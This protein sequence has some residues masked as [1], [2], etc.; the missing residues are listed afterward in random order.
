[1]PSPSP[2]PTPPPAGPNAAFPLLLPGCLGPPLPPQLTLLQLIDAW[3]GS[4]DPAVSKRAK[5]FSHEDA[6]LVVAQLLYD[7]YVQLAFGHTAYVS[8]VK[9]LSP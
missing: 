9:S 5:T 2:T 6:E 7:G 1:M 8:A 4:K 3:R